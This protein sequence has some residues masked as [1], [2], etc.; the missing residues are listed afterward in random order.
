MK[1]GNEIWKK[2]KKHH[3]AKNNKTRNR[4]NKRPIEWKNRKKEW[5]NKKKENKR[6]EKGKEKYILNFKK[7]E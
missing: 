1:E 2:T 3:N 5:M 6:T 4:R 7:H